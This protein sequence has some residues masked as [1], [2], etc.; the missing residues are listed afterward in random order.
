MD[1]YLS[2]VYYSPKS[3]ASYYGAER[4][5]DYIKTREDAPTNLH[6]AGVKRWLKEQTTHSIHTKPQQHFTTERIIVEYP[7]MQWDSDLLQLT[8]LSEYNDGYKYLLVCIDLFSRYLWV[9]PLKS[10]RTSEVANR[11]KHVISEGR[12]CEILRT[13]Q[14]KEFTG[15][16]FQ[17]LLKE[18]G[19]SHM[20]A[21]GAHKASYAERVN[22]S[23]EERLY[24]YFYEKQ[25]FRYIDI[26]EDIIW[27]YNHTK[28]SSIGIPPAEVNSVNTPD[29]YQRVYVPE[30]N[31]RANHRPKH[32]FQVGDLVRLSR[33]ESPFDHGYQ[34]HWTEELFRVIQSLPSHPPRY[35]VQDLTDEVI[36]GSFYEEELLKV[37]VI[38]P[39]DIVYKIESVVSTKTVRGKKLSLIKW[40]GYSDKFNSYIPTESIQEYL[41]K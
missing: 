8:G 41:S 29:I 30:L 13:D 14:G 39:D 31:K 23:I 20:L 27:S 12:K 5:W 21:Y 11:F 10:K 7:D 6:R 19:V 40:Y 38:N 32:S 25:T 22:R 36:K 35:K 2:A 9:Q 16:A 34:E 1:Q 24:K 4:L 33:K 17:E 3:P 37:N 28:H 15:T 26:L 18:E